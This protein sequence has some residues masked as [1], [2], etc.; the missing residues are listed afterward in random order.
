VNLHSLAFVLAYVGAF[1]GVAMVLPQLVRT[2]RLPGMPGVSA[3]SWS[4]TALASLG[5]LIYGLRTA[6]F[7]QIPG[8]VPLVAGAVA[9]VLLVPSAVSRSRRALGLGVAAAAIVASSTVVPAQTVGYLAFGIG[10]LSAWP[11]LFESFGNWRT[12]GESGL[13]LTTWSVK[14]G[15]TS[16]WLSYA[17][18]AA[19]LPVLVACTVGM[20]TT[21]AIVGLETSA[22]FS[23]RRGVLETA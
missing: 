20:T 10:L 7:A 6:T 15:A 4:L 19:D 23:A 1:L 12:G 13:S 8:N 14:I 16:C 3:L 2:I 9:V 21:L 22:R 11:Q 17:I 18:L 5:W